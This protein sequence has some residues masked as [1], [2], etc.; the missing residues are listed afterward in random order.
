M[1]RSLVW[2]VA[3][4]SLALSGCASFQDKEYACAQR[5]RALKAWYFGD[6]GRVCGSPSSHYAKGW[7]AGYRAI[8]MGEDGQAPPVPPTMYWSHKYQNPNGE[9]KISEW[10]S[11]YERG[12]AAAIGTGRGEY[13][14]IASSPL[15]RQFRPATLPTDRSPYPVG[16]TTLEVI[17]RVDLPPGEIPPSPRGSGAS[18]ANPPMVPGESVEQQVIEPAVPMTEPMTEPTTE[19]VDPATEPM[20]PMADPMAPETTENYDE[21]RE[22]MDDDAMTDMPAEDSLDDAA[23]PGDTVIEE[24]NENLD[25][26]VP[27]S[28]EGDETEAGES[29]EPND[30]AS[31]DRPDDSEYADELTIPT[32]DGTCDND[33]WGEFE[34]DMAVGNLE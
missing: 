7:R 22:A 16:K 27:T 25:D 10:F 33:T 17:P 8:L 6:E 21:D 19:P 1:M 18:R 13:H 12:V 31:L 34:I 5:M 4:T 3:L 32:E 15:Y 26:A 23:A 24:M 28:G 20:D 9:Q 29:P 11:G 2:F 14:Q 30:G